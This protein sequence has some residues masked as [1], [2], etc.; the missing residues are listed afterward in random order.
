MFARSNCVTDSERFYNTI[1]DL[2]LEVRELG[3]INQL[4][5]W[6]NVYVE[7][8]YSV[9]CNPSHRFRQIFPG[10][11]SQDDSIAED[12]PLAMIRKRRDDLERLAALEAN[13]PPAEHEEAEN[14]GQGRDG[15]SSSTA[16]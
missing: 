10:A 14:S 13:T 12:A 8:F 7:Y 2:F 11:M 9:V 16:D 3:E 1:M 15:Q 6:W 5:A 4:I